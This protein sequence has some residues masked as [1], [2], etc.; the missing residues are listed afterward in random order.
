MDNIYLASGGAKLEVAKQRAQEADN[1][2]RNM[3]QRQQV[4]NDTRRVG[5]QEEELGIRK[6]NSA[7]DRLNQQMDL[8]LKQNSF[9]REQYETSLLKNMQN[10]VQPVQNQETQGQDYSRLAQQ[11]RQLGMQMNKV[12][13]IKAKKYFDAADSYES[14]ASNRIKTSLEIKSKQVE[15]AGQILANIGSQE[16]LNSALPDLFAVGMEVPPEMRD[17]NNPKTKQWIDKQAFRSPTIA[18][19][20]Q[21]QSAYLSDIDTLAYDKQKNEVIDE[22]RYNK[23]L[24]E[25]AAQIST[26]MKASGSPRGAQFIKMRAEQIMGATEELAR[27][28]QIIGKFPVGTTSGIFGEYGGEKS[29][30]A[31]P[32]NAVARFS[33]SEEEAKFQTTT[34]NI[35]Q[36]LAIIEAGGYKPNQAQIDNYNRKF[37]F[38]KGTTIGT[39]MF[40]IAD[41][42]A[43]TEARLKIL[44]ANPDVPSAQKRVIEDTMTNLMQ[45]FPLSPENLLDAERAGVSYQEAF[46]QK[47]NGTLDRYLELKKKAGK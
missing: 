4:F 36:A 38:G 27:S 13:P 8:R 34:S 43:Q 11:N 12:D 6:E 21:D 29:F 2:R 35:G 9:E 10:A 47:K 45:Q 42:I 31:A 17:W 7:L 32:L 40:T 5:I 22:N 26:D 33:T 41:A 30:T 25:R 19:D 46:N 23:S 3:L 1:I 24:R 44:Q 14:A 20:L 16:D 39:R 28:L 18:K 37:T 15:Q